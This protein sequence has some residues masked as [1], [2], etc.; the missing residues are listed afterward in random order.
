M[1]SNPALHELLAT[2]QVRS[3][4]QWQELIRERLGF[5]PSD[6]PVLLLMLVCRQLIT[7]TGWN[8]TVRVYTA[9]LDDLGWYVIVNPAGMW[10]SMGYSN[11]GHHSAASSLCSTVASCGYII[12]HSNDD[13]TQAFS[14][15]ERSRLMNLPSATLTI[16][17]ET[18][19]DRNFSVFDPFSTHASIR[20]VPPM[21]KQDCLAQRQ[22]KVS[23]LPNTEWQAEHGNR[24]EYLT[25]AYVYDDEHPGEVGELLTTHV[26]ST[27][28]R[29]NSV[30]KVIGGRTKT[31]CEKCNAA[32]DELCSTGLPSLPQEIL[33]RK[34][35]ASRGRYIRRHTIIARWKVA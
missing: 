10:E 23:P 20:A 32:Y 12:H 13:H 22:L 9:L 24:V 30:Q 35:G 33:R 18:R 34:A 29:K 2:T 31:I 15:N 28:A 17:N 5:F 14:D 16:R 21:S 3:L 6:F 26:C 7:M 19:G 11:L 1:E 27:I 8:N 25:M 4:M